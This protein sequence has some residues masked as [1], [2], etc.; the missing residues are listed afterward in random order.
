M[1]NSWM[2]PNWRKIGEHVEFSN[3]FWNLSRCYS[4]LQ[5][6]N[7]WAANKLDCIQMT[8]KKL[9]IILIFTLILNKETFATVLDPVRDLHLYSVAST[10]QDEHLS[11]PTTTQ[12]CV[13]VTGLVRHLSICGMALRTVL[14]LTSHCFPSKVNHGYFHLKHT[15]KHQ[16][17]W[18][19]KISG[20]NITIYLYF[21]GKNNSI[22]IYTCMAN[23]IYCESIV[24][25]I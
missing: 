11:L 24:N 5:R 10:L 15:V 6:K 13:Q 8:F 16:H 19:M 3:I 21:L 4:M 25:L 22:T 2:D 7:I 20:Y 17:I 9:R 23:D 18:I 14:I 1:K 12:L